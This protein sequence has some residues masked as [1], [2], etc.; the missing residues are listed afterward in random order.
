MP[1]TEIWWSEL[2]GNFI[3]LFEVRARPIISTLDVFDQERRKFR[4][5]VYA[6]RYGTIPVVHCI[7]RVLLH[8][9]SDNSR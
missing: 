5:P 1:P 7:D 9:A 3:L 6:M 4:Q 8:K 2:T